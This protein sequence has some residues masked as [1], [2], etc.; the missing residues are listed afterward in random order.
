MSNVTDGNEGVM[1]LNKKR[2]MLA[3]LCAATLGFLRQKW[4]RKGEVPVRSGR[5]LLTGT[6]EA[7]PFGASQTFYVKPLIHKI[8]CRARIAILSHLPIPQPAG[9]GGCGADG[10]GRPPASGGVSATGSPCLRHTRRGPWPARL[11]GV[12][13]Q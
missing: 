5:S 2:R 4:T 9:V 3:L 1:H 8:S 12:D 13:A 7:E 6:P 10:A 11:V